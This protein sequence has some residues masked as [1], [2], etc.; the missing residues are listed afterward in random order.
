LRRPRQNWTFA[1]ISKLE[2]MYSITHQEGS[3]NCLTDEIVAGWVKSYFIQSIHTRGRISLKSPKNPMFVAMEVNNSRANTKGDTNTDPLP[4]KPKH[5]IHKN[6]IYEEKKTFL[7]NSTFLK[8]NFFNSSSTSM[9]SCPA[10]RLAK[11]RFS[12][13]I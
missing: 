2:F 8:N 6:R 10:D 3:P 12:R 7:R 11:D 13:A 5:I 1:N 9:I 4:S